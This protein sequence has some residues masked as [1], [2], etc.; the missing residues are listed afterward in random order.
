[1]HPHSSPAPRFHGLGSSSLTEALLCWFSRHRRE[2]PWRRNRTPYTVWIAEVMLQQTRS[3]TVLHYYEKF[4]ARFPDI[5]TLAWAPLDAVLKTWE[6]L[7]Y[8]ARARNLR[9]TARQL[10]ATRGSLPASYE[11]LLALPGIGPYTAGA[12][13][14]I[15]FGLPVVALDGNARRVLVRVLAAEGNPR[16]SSVQ[17]QLTTFAES[18]LPPS[19]PGTFNE[20]LMELGATV[21]TARA[22]CCKCCPISQHCQAQQQGRADE[23][24]IRPRRRVIPHHNVAAGIILRAGSRRILLAQRSP[25][26]FLGGLWEFP[27]GTQE[28]GESLQ[29]CLMREL[30]EE[31]GIEV[32]VEEQLLSIKHAYTHFRITLHAFLCRLQAGEPRCL[33]CADLGWVAPS[34]LDALPMAVTDRRIAQAVQSLVG[35][36]Q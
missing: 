11:G 26:D 17:R 28:P 6:G 36:D 2:L 3:E 13:A 4:L 34:E 27:G 23:L 32:D 14:S 35:L 15:A 29:T 8:Y 1:M 24:P 31:L 16:L 25:D 7:G 18:L 12:V 21:C 5:R 9:S 10:M 33:E 20:A 30:R 19:S 22:P